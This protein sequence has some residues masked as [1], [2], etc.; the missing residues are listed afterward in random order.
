M[1]RYPEKV[2]QT[3]FGQRTSFVGI[4]WEKPEGVDVDHYE[5]FISSREADPTQIE[6]F[7]RGEVDF[8]KKYSFDNT[9]HSVV[10]NRT[11]MFSR[12]LYSVFVV[13]K[14]GNYVNVPFTIDD[15]KNLNLKSPKYIA[16]EE[17]PW[18]AEMAA[19]KPSQIAAKGVKPIAVEEGPVGTS[20]GAKPMAVEEG[21][22]GIE[23]IKSLIKSHIQKA[24]E[25]ADPWSMYPIVFIYCYESEGK[26]LMEISTDTQQLPDGTWFFASGFELRRFSYTLSESQI[27]GEI[28]NDRPIHYLDSA[29][30]GGH[31]F[32]I[33]FVGF[34]AASSA[35]LYEGVGVPH[36]VELNGCKISLISFNHEGNACQKVYNFTAQN[37]KVSEIKLGL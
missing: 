24:P 14:A 7:C 37:Y 25:K 11:P 3:R 15:S 26:L 19:A 8:A 30:S 12:M 21:P 10:D 9:V 28:V 5:I 36:H 34:N 29:H 4:V 31:N 1:E 18:G 2:N 33:Y 23:K 13:D 35:L 20:K 27:S 16:V 6:S 22:V 32:N 17:G